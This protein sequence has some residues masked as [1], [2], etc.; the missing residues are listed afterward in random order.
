[1]NHRD[2]YEQ[3]KA[4]IRNRFSTVEEITTK[5]VRELPYLDAVLREGRRLASIPFGPPR[6]VPPE[7]AKIAGIWVE[8]NVT[9]TTRRVTNYRHTSQWPTFP[10]NVIHAISLT[11]NPSSPNDG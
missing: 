9:P 2:V 11:P 6:L 3:L 8:G 4:E 7:G 1:L 10:C 5:S